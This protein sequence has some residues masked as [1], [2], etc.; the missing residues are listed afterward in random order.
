MNFLEALKSGK[1]F[2][3]KGLNF[4]DKAW[5]D[6]ESHEIEYGWDLETML[7]EWEVEEDPPSFKSVEGPHEHELDFE[8]EC[9]WRCKHCHKEIE[10]T[11]WKE[12]RK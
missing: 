7:G 10:P 1:R 8:F 12:R 6:Q 3:P 2:R 5:E 11:G 4:P 9:L